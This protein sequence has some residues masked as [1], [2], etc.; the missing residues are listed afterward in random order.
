MWVLVHSPGVGQR[1]LGGQSS[2]VLI[3]AGRHNVRITRGGRPGIEL[4]EVGPRSISRSVWPVTPLAR[5]T[6]V[7][8]GSRPLASAW[9]DT[10]MPRQPSYYIPAVLP[11]SIEEKNSLLGEAA[12]INPTI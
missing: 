6:S 4:R 5:D 7:R 12:F 2:V 10:L 9:H 8:L 1:V 11:V 3:P